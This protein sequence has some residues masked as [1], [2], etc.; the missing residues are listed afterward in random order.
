MFSTKEVYIII[1]VN[2]LI[3][4][5][6]VFW[7]VTPYGLIQDYRLYRGAYCLHHQGDRTD[8]GGSKYL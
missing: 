6:T 3:L 1:Q 7:D 2:A 5:M 4:K 8:D